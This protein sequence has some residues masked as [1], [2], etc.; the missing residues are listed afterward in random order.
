M[1]G[2]RSRTSTQVM[3][4]LEAQRTALL[5]GDLDRLGKMEAEL[6]KA[7]VRLNRDGGKLSALEQIKAGAA[8]NAQL[9]VSA[10]A[11]VA[12]A[13]AHLSAA[14]APDLTTYDAQ[15]RSQAT[16]PSN[17]RELARR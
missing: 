14:R 4:L 11:G 17:S 2:G 16:T 10:Q 12:A 3:D 8:R 9:L 15:G 7:F 1:M 5:E 13:R 6:S